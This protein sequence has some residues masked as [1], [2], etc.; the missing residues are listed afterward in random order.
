LKVDERTNNLVPF[1]SFLTE[2]SITTLSF[3]L[4]LLMQL[5]MRY[6]NERGHEYGQKCW[7]AWFPKGKEEE[8]NRRLNDK[9]TEK[10]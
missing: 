9:A 5:D 10:K 6:V 3:L 8:K 1:Q 4:K 2:Y 7:E